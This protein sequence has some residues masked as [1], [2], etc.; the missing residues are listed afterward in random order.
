MAS[1]YQIK[2]RFQSLLR[3]LVQRLA[4]IGVTAN[5]VTVAAICLS[6]LGGYWIIVSPTQQ[7]PWLLFPIVLF[8]RM[9]LNAIDGMLAREHHMKSNLGAILNE[10]GD[11]VSDLFLYLPFALRTDISGWLVV[12]VCFL[13]V[14]SEM[15]GLIGILVGASRRYDGPMGKS[16]RAFVFGAGG[17]AYGFEI[18]PGIWPDCILI[19]MAGLLVLT[20]YN[21]ANGALM[22]AG[23]YEQ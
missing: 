9:A 13:A 16:D 8:L 11:V 3:P 23:A 22:E 7:W 2:S 5:Q 14:I 6:A 17:L 12:A 19:V 21:R 15:A 18:T 1:I 10:L 4:G 20:V